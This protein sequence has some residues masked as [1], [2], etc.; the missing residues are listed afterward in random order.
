MLALPIIM[1]LLLIIGGVSCVLTPVVTFIETGYFL[2]IFLFVSGILGLIVE[3]SRKNFGI[4]FLYSI[5]SIIFALVI[6]CVPSFRLMTDSVVLYLIALW[7]VLRGI[8]SIFLSIKARKIAPNKFWICGIIIGILE[9]IVGV[10][11]FAHPMVTALT[12]GVLI[13]CYFIMTG[14]DLIIIPFEIISNE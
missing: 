10:Y 7:F 6:L 2:T 9:L 8:I 5:L 13:G 12:I 14:I 11:S 3:I 4:N 1:G